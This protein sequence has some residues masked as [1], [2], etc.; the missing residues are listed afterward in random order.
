MRKRRR[1]HISWEMPLKSLFDFLPAKQGSLGWGNGA[2]TGSE[3]KRSGGEIVG[4]IK[5][6]AEGFFEWK[7]IYERENVK[8]WFDFQRFGPKDI[9]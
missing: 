6:M 5:G 1:R 8:E 4:K 9:V 7:N 2:M 3:W